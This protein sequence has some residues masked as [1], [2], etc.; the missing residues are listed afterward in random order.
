M[1]FGLTDKQEKTIRD[2]LSSYQEVETAMIFGSRAMNTFEA[3]SDVDIALKGKVPRST[4]VSIK[5]EL[6]DTTLP[7]FFDI[8]DYA[9]I[10]EP[11]LKEQIDK[12]GKI[13]YLKGWKKTT[14]GEVAK[15]IS[16]GTPKTSVPEY[17]NGDI[18]WLSVTDFNNENRW[19]NQTEK[20]ITKKG[21]ENS[22]TKLLDAG[23]IVI[24]DRGTVGVFAQLKRPMAFNQSCYGI[25]ENTN[26]TKDFLFY[27]IKQNNNQLKKNVHGAVFDTITRNTFD[28]IEILLPSIQEQRAIAAVLSSLDDKI[29]LLREQNKTLESTA[30]A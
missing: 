11:K 12:H 30:Q 25:K 18:P 20:H 23:D 29:E 15:I 6:E 9:S 21:L 27:L 24:S 26:S 5:S 7:Y 16:G 22:S 8:L 28:Q 17:W 14:L 3:G 4:I 19:V 13:F 10:N 1:S 2:V